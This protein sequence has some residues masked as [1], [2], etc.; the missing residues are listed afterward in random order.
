MP[1]SAIGIP[2]FGDDAKNSASQKYVLNTQVGLCLHDIILFS[3]ELQSGGGQMARVAR[4][5][6]TSVQLF[7]EDSGGQRF[8]VGRC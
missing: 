3:T 8:V 4:L 7:S 1:L 5:H 6:P 2:G